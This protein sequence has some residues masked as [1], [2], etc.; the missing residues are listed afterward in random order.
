LCRSSQVSAG[1][2]WCQPVPVPLTDRKK[3]CKEKFYQSI[4]SRNFSKTKYINQMIF[5]IYFKEFQA[6]K[7]QSKTRFKIKLQNSIH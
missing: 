4:F 6:F 3:R 1:A 5:F 7:K 2:G